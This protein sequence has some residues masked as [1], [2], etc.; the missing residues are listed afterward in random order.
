VAAG[1]A[2]LNLILCMVAYDPGPYVGGDN[3]TYVSLAR[4]LLERGAYL[5]YWDP[6]MRPHTAYPPVF[7]L[8]LAGGM[9]LGLPVWGGVKM[10]CVV[11]SAAAAGLSALW[12]RRILP[13][14]PA[15]IAGALVAALPGALPLANQVIS[16]VPFWCWTMLGLW[17]YER[18]V[19]AERPVPWEALGAAALILAYFTRAAGLPL[20]LAACCW[21][22]LRRQWRGLAILLGPLVPLVVAWSLRNRALGG[23][24][25]YA[26]EFW[27][28]DPYEPDQGTIGVVDMLDRMLSNVIRYG[29][30]HIPTLLMDDQPR[31]AWWPT[32]LAAA[33]VIAAV[34][35]WAMRLR[36]PTTAE[37]FVPLYV[38]LLLVWPATWSGERFVLPIMPLLMG[39]ATLSLLALGQRIRQ[40]MIPAVVAA[41][42]VSG[43][44]YLGL[45]YYAALGSRCRAEYR[46]G[47][48]SPCLPSV[49]SELLGIGTLVRGRI[50]EDAVVIHRKP[51]LFFAISG[52]RSRLYPKTENPDSFFAM[53]RETGADF[54][55]VDQ[56]SDMA[57][58]LHAVLIA[59]QND[60][61]VIRELSYPNAMLARIV[62]NA[63][64]PATPLG[65]DEVRTCAHA[66]GPP[67]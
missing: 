59:R 62:E 60:F 36:R 20:V 3:G 49:W 18:A 42:V 61:C 41:G 50:P 66:T 45:S 10:L 64:P 19:D 51:T 40:P 54:V 16:D 38:G 48:P 55:V 24:S 23:S 22:V 37:L 46:A 6:A 7:P 29:Q 14:Y 63:P 26:R 53:V 35:G 2:L 44:M 28:K 25:V 43:V 57:P 4:G 33:L 27:W 67:F 32:G 47:N 31:E 8:I 58:Y 39:Y 12:L 5:D 1:A 56:I 17:A 30:N 52:H 9:W 65:R 21:M 15:L 11:F 13:A 34:A